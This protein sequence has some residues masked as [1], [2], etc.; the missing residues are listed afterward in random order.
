MV[1]RIMQPTA[2]PNKMLDKQ[3]RSQK[4]HAF[5]IPLASV[6]TEKK[7]K[8]KNAIHRVDNVLTW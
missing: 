7:K 6:I 8:K 5:Y 2:E 4:S 1:Q 3:S